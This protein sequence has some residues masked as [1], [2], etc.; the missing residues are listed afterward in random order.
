MKNHFE[1]KDNQLYWLIDQYWKHRQ[2][3][4]QGSEEHLNLVGQDYLT[5]GNYYPQWL[6]L[7]DDY[8]GFNQALNTF[9]GKQYDIYLYEQ[10]C[11]L[12]ANL[13]ESKNFAIDQHFAQELAVL[14]NQIINE[15]QNSWQTL[16]VVFQKLNENTTLSQSFKDV[17]MD[18]CFGAMQNYLL[19]DK[20]TKTLASKQ[21]DNKLTR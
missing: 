18:A 3:E 2:P 21:N 19:N 14:A 11:Q 6:E 1:D 7:K 4:N 17:Q 9:Y 20:W 16:W 15:D 10:L 8:E 13:K 12:I 5:I